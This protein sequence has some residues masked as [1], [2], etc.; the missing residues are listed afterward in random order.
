MKAACGSRAKPMLDATSTV[1]AGHYGFT[2]EELDFIPPNSGRSLSGHFVG[3]TEMVANGSTAR[4][5]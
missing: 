4:A 5:E 1:L 3:I 2:A